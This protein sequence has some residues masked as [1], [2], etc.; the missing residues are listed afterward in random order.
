[1]VLTRQRLSED[2]NKDKNPLKFKKYSSEF[3]HHE[4]TKALHRMIWCYA[5][6]KTWLD[7]NC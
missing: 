3:A 1:M 4:I 2:L 7:K 6:P 5:N